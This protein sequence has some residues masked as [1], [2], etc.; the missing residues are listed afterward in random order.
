MYVT[1]MSNILEVRRALHMAAEIN[2][3]VNFIFNDHEGYE[4]IFVVTNK[5]ERI[6]RW[7]VIDDFIQISIRKKN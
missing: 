3:G 2:K 1:E 4:C 7:Q 5:R 6:L